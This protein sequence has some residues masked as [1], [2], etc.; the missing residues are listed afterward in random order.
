MDVPDV[1]YARSGDVAIA[2]HVSGGG[3]FD[4]VF[5]GG[6]VTHLTH[7]VQH[8][9]I[10]AFFDRL[11]SLGRLIRFD[12]RGVGLSDR[13]RVV[14]TLEARMDDIRAV[15][16]A[17][18]SR[19][20]ALIATGEAG[21]M[22]TLFAAT[23]PERTGGLVL[24]NPFARAIEAPDYPI[25]ESEA[26]WLRQLAE[27]DANWGKTD[28]F[29][30]QFSE[31]WPDFQ[32]DEGALRWYCETLRCGA[33]PGAALTV[34]RMA[35]DVDVRDVLAAIRVPV[36]ILYRAGVEGSA[37]DAGYMAERIPGAKCVAIPGRGQPWHA[38]AERVLAEI[39]AFLPVGYGTAEPDTVL[40]T[41]LFTDIVGST[42]HVAAVGDRRWRETILRHDAI[43]RRCL[44]GFRGRELDTAG[45]GF[46]SSFDGPA[47]AIRCAV[48][49]SDAVGELDIQV[50]SGLHTGECEI[51]GD[52]IAGLAVN[53]GARIAA[54]AAPGEVLVSSTVK[55][56]VAGSD[57]AFEDR[58]VHELK[59][60]PG[61]WRL[62][63]VS[64]A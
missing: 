41:V 1:S 61:E 18:G 34:H 40:S 46:F 35:M 49:I 3:E 7:L 60:V 25:G 12:R 42:Q 50:R 11:S 16:E 62:Y 52:K 22:A 2:Y 33:S 63:A 54:K 10:A 53:V 45:D 43:V 56:L 26:E 59:G 24:W 5:A 58:G 28:F 13:P 27:I 44:D 55:D 48:A 17:A 9:P 64:P 51:R 20:A 36:L 14:P 4:L 37:D 31:N 8:P 47:R 39:E 19:R 29:E 23:Y 15:M 6:Y 21:A 38:G 57:I 32:G 30:K